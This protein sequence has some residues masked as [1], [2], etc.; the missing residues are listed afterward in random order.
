LRRVDSTKSVNRT[1]TVPSGISELFTC[2]C[3]GWSEA[4][5]KRTARPLGTVGNALQGLCR[6]RRSVEHRLRAPL[7][8][9]DLVVPWSDWNSGSEGQGSMTSVSFCLDHG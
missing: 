6:A 3:T 8:A 7:M 2:A 5:S 9:T 4:R 1:V